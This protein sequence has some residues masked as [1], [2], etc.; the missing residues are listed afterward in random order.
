VKI[1]GK[2]IQ[3]TVKKILIN[4]NVVISPP[5]SFTFIVNMDY[6]I[7][8]VQVYS[9]LLQYKEVFNIK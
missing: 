4:P 1:D 6:F 7:P 8:V 5:P 2:C 9:C 3:V